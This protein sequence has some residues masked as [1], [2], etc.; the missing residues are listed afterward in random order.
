MKEALWTPTP[1]RQQA[2]RM[3]DFLRFAETRTG[4]RSDGYPALYDWSVRE[5]QAFW[6]VLWDYFDILCSRKAG[7]F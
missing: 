7:H 1:E 6:D 5:P 2:S 3:Q 4:D